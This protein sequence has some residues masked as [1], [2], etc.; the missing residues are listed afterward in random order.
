MCN[1]Y[2]ILYTNINLQ[3]QTDKDK[4]ANSLTSWKNNNNSNHILCDA[5]HQNQTRFTCEGNINILK[6]GKSYCFPLYTF[7]DIF[8]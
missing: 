7:L 6:Y 2:E 8:V 1:Y 3:I 4:C 5:L